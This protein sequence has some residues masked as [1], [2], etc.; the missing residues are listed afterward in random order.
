MRMDVALHQGEGA[1]MSSAAGA[2]VAVQWHRE[3]VVGE[4]RMDVALHQGEGA[5]MSSAAGA[6][7]AVQWHREEVVEDAHLDVPGHSDEDIHMI[8]AGAAGVAAHNSEAF[9]TAEDVEMDPHRQEVVRRA[10]GIAVPVFAVGQPAGAGWVVA[11]TACCIATIYCCRLSS[12]S[13]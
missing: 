1:C 7:V 13:C 11:G 5:C 12:G 4:M 9:C 6:G 2:G 3:E 10:V 8:F